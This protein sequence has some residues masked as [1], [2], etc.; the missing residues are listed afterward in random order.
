MENKIHTLTE[1]IK[2]DEII[3][4]LELDINKIFFTGTEHPIEVNNRIE[5]NKRLFNKLTNGEH[6]VY[7]KA[8]PYQHSEN[9]VRLV[10]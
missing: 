2:I 7:G 1:L 9:E 4:R 3:Q 6:Y 8:Y 5:Y 10:A